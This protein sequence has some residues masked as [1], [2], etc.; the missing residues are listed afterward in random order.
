[1]TCRIFAGLAVLIALGFCASFEARADKIVDANHV[2][3][4]QLNPEFHPE[5][6][7]RIAEALKRPPIDWSVARDHTF[8]E[9]S[10]PIQQRELAAEMISQWEALLANPI[11]ANFDD[12]IN[13]HLRSIIKAEFA[14]QKGRERVVAIE[15]EIAWDDLPQVNTG[16]EVM[17]LIAMDESKFPL[18]PYGYDEYNNYFEPEIYDWFVFVTDDLTV[19]YVYENSD[20]LPSK[21]DPVLLA[22]QNAQPVVPESFQVFVRE[23]VQAIASGEIAVSKLFS[24]IQERWTAITQPIAIASLRK[25]ELLPAHRV[26]QLQDLLRF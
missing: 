1:M 11:Y 6:E 7:F 24:A 20:V 10:E 9:K 5:V 13:A 2:V 19:V 22:E 25:T 4:V 17:A 8:A 23:Q 14:A 16:E 12:S 21:V 15:S 26:S 3:S 18:D